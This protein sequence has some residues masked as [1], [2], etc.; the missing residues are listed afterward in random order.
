VYQS[1]IAFL[2]LGDGNWRQTEAWIVRL[3]GAV[4]VNTL[5]Q[6]ALRQF[7][8][9]LWIAHP[10]FQLEGGHFTT[11]LFVT[12]FFLSMLCSRHI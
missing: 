3:A 11:E 4:E 5:A 9:W 6:G 10:T 7:T 1:H 8:Q 2:I 12:P